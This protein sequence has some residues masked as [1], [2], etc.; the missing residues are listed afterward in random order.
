MRET[1]SPGITSTRG[2]LIDRS[3]Q[4]PPHVT[5]PLSPLTIPWMMHPVPLG[6]HGNS[7]G[8]PDP[9]PCDM[10][11]A[12]I[13]ASLDPGWAASCLQSILHCPQA[14]SVYWRV[15]PTTCLHCPKTQKA[16]PNLSPTLH[17]LPLPGFQ[18]ADLRQL[19]RK[20]EKKPSHPRSP[21]PSHI[22]NLHRPTLAVEQ[23]SHY[24]PHTWGQSQ[25]LLC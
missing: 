13:S 17:F 8:G 22:R 1:T 21:K 10:T 15:A 12:S 23:R 5:C 2:G 9:L 18:Q 25:P 14:T 16:Q 7:Q 20:P 6:F 19:L 3:T 11:T 24:T 4:Q